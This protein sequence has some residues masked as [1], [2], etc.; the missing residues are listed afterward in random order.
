MYNILREYK[1]LTELYT[2]SVMHNKFKKITLDK[3]QV[4]CK[5]FSE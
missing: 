2:I 5:S 3:K 4:P 1:I